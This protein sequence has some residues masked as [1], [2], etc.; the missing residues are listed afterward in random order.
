MV[1]LESE[2]VEI[3]TAAAERA[4]GKTISLEYYIDISQC[5]SRPSQVNRISPA[6]A[7]HCSPERE[8]ALVHGTGTLPPMHLIEISAFQDI[9]A[10]LPLFFG[11]VLEDHWRILIAKNKSSLIIKT[12]DMG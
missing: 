1:R 8:F 5:F 12:E 10:L 9:C 3:H 6:E 11:G 4:H 2:W 7:V